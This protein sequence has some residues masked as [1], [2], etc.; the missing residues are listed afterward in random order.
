[1]SAI[2]KL[3]AAHM[4][5]QIVLG[6]KFDLTSYEDLSLPPNSSIIKQPGMEQA[7]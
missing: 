1:M 3:L 2:V 7:S 6:V 5:N 4:F